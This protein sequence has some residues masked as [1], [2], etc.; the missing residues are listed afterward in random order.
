MNLRIRFGLF[1]A[2]SAACQIAQAGVTALPTAPDGFAWV[3]VDNSVQINSSNSGA[4]AT[5]TS[6]GLHVHDPGGAAPAATSASNSI[7]MSQ[8]LTHSAPVGSGESGSPMEGDN[9]FLFSGSTYETSVGVSLTSQGSARFDLA[10]AAALSSTMGPVGSEGTFTITESFEAF[11]VAVSGAA[12]AN[13]SQGATSVVNTFHANDKDGVG[14]LLPDASATLFEVDFDGGPTG[15][16]TTGA[17][18]LVR[19]VDDSDGGF[20]PMGIAASSGS[21]GQGDYLFTVA[22]F[23]HTL[24]A[25][26]ISTDGLR[27]LEATEYQGTSSE[28]E[29]ELLAS[30]TWTYSEFQLMAVPEPGSLTLVLMGFAGLLRRRRR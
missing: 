4:P 2:F 3:L 22:D 24:A 23:D 7:G 20:N 28:V 14:F 17:P 12:T 11:S 25:A 16:S 5:T 21:G 27:V 10:R 18:P 15:D 6:G 29:L 1:C 30:A 9:V 19:D 8:T 26:L 13:H